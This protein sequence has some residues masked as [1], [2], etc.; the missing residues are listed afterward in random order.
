MKVS[1]LGT[2]KSVT[3]RIPSQLDLLNGKIYDVRVTEDTTQISANEAT[4]DQIRTAMDNVT[5]P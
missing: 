1:Y 2:T 3:F 4:V 5:A